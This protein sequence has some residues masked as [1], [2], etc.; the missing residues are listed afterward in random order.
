MKVA[1]MLFV[2]LHCTGCATIERTVNKIRN[3]QPGECLLYPKF[4]LQSGNETRPNDWS[5]RLIYACTLG[6]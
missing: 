2:V 4:K 3:P 6:V 5:A 1:L